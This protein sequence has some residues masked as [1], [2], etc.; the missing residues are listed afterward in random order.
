MIRHVVLLKWR[1]ELSPTEM[2]EVRSCLDK[3]GAEAPSVGAMA[4]GS[5]L[6]IAGSGAD[7]A[8]TADFDD[9]AGWRAYAEHPSHDLP[10]QVLRRLA[11]EVTAIQFTVPD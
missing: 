9:A 3:L 8:L 6:S 4:H 10:R 2:T 5:G 7:Y 1:K 11:S